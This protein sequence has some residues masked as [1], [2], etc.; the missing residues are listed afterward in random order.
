LIDE[1]VEAGLQRLQHL[2]TLRRYASEANRCIMSEFSIGF[3]K[4]FRGGKLAFKLH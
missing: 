4:G 1:N 3:G 2:I